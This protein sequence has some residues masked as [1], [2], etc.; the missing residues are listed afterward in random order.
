MPGAAEGMEEDHFYCNVFSVVPR[1][2][3]KPAAKMRKAIH[4]QES[5]AAAMEKARSVAAAL[6]DWK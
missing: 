2:K 4:A 5:K 3:V 6:R 1:A